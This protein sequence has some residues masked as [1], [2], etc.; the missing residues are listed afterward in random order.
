MHRRLFGE[1]TRGLAPPHHLA[2]IR[3]ERIVDDPLGGIKRVVIPVAEM[4]EAFG[5]CL[6]TRSLGLMV[7]RVVGIGA[8]DD[9]AQPAR[10]QDRPSACTS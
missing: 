4:P 7:E 6:E 3:V 8:V 10:G 9:P 5:H 1:L 2:A